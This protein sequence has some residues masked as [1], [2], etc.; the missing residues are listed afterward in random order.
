M[1]LDGRGVGDETGTLIAV[2]VADHVVACAG[3]SDGAAV[4]EDRP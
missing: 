2:V 1:D 4:G 3:A